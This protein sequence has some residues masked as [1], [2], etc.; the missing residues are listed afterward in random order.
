MAT[1]ATA[2][3][4]L[5]EFWKRCEEAGKNREGSVKTAA[6]SVERQPEHAAGAALINAAA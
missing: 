6:G 5:H 1:A 3:E 4:R 2:G